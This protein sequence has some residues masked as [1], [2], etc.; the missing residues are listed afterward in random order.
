MSFE[1]QGQGQDQGQRQ[2]Q[3]QGQ[4]QDGDKDRAQPLIA[5]AEA[6]AMRA[7]T[8]IIDSRACTVRAQAK[9]HVPWW[10]CRG[11]QR[12]ARAHRR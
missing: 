6:R 4:G 7:V 2:D 9:G 3:G 1:D 5:A 8:D 10:T 11:D 12:G